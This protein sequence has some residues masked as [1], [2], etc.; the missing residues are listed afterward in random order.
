M[1]SIPAC[2]SWI[3]DIHRKATSAVQISSIIKELSM[4]LGSWDGELNGCAQ[5]AAPGQRH[6]TERPLG[7]TW[8]TQQNK[9]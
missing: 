2:H 4:P 7:N 6:G 9:K 5:S 3:K 8:K 1:A